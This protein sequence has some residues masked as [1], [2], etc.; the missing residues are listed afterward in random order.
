MVQAVET[1]AIKMENMND[2]QIVEI[3]FK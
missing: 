1:Y 2:I 3:T